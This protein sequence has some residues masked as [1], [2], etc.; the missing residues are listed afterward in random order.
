MVHGASRDQ[1][2]AEVARLVG[3]LGP[4]CCY[5]H[6]VLFSNR[7]WKMIGCVP[8]SLLPAVQVGRIWRNG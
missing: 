8:G 2:R 5:P 4:A 7:I 3:Q 1:V 6:D